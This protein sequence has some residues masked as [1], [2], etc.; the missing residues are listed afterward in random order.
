MLS[1]RIGREKV[2]IMGYGAFL[3]SALLLS[4]RIMSL[5][6]IFLVALV[7]GVYMGIGETIQRAMV[8]KYAPTDLKG[9][10]YGIY[11]LVVGTGYF[12]ANSVFGA[13]WNYAGSVVAASYCIG[14]SI[15]A[16]ISMII[17]LRLE[18][19]L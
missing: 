17:F 6:Y 11:Y 7:Y 12:V 1:D 16:I 8:P 4:Q 15:A 19:R 14:T 9:T 13:L 3:V 10:A 2:L 5:A 18:K